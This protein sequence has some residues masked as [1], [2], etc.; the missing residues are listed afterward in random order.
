[1]TRREALQ[2]LAL[3]LLAACG[4]SYRSV[5]AQEKGGE[6]LI[7]RNVFSD[8]PNDLASVLVRANGRAIHLVRNESLSYTAFLAECTH[9]GCI[10]EHQGSVFVCPCHGSEFGIDGKV[11]EGPATRNLTE[12]PVS[13]RDDAFVIHLVYQD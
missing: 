8:T 12:F 9:K 2:L 11:Q 6:L 4:S 7:D 5:Q 10:V 3:P 1:M 13:V